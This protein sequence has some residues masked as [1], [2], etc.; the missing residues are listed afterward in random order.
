MSEG[1]DGEGWRGGVGREHLALNGFLPYL[2]DGPWLV[3]TGSNIT[4]SPL[5]KGRGEMYST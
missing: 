2:V 4:R 5:G 1:R 3:L